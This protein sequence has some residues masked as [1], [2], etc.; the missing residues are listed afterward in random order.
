[1][2]QLKGG[3][4]PD[5]LEYAGCPTIAADMDEDLPAKKLV[6]VESKGRAMIANDTGQGSYLDTRRYRRVKCVKMAMT[7]QIKLRYLEA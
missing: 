2:D 6:D 7:R 5:M 4:P 3:K 1:M